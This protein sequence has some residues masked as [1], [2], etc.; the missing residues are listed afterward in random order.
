MN[1]KRLA[2]AR[3]QAIAGGGPRSSS[4]PRRCSDF[5]GGATMRGLGFAAKSFAC[6]AS[7]R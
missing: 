5:P 3:I 7:E 1:P 6:S 4:V 2:F